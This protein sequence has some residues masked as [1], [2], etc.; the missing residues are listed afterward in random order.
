MIPRTG[1]NSTNI[2][3][4]HLRWMDTESD[5]RNRLMDR[6]FDISK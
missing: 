2:M 4:D 1:P 5:P 6:A 3:G